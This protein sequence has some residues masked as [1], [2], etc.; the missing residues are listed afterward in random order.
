MGP[1]RIRPWCVSSAVAACVSRQVFNPWAPDS[2]SFVYITAEGMTH[3][4]LDPSKHCL[5][6]DKWQ[7]R[8]ATFGTW[9][10]F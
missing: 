1:D 10:R 8:G 2:R 9:S 3:V 5:G 7:N 6:Q 4:P